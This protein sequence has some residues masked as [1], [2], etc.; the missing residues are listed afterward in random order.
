MDSTRLLIVDADETASDRLVM[1]LTAG[2]LNI[3][4]ERADTP[5]GIEVALRW[6]EPHVVLLTAG[7]PGVDSM[8]VL[9]LVQEVCPHVQLV[10]VMNAP[11]D[12]PPPQVGVRAAGCIL[13]SDP[14]RLHEAVRDAAKESRT[15]RS[16]WRADRALKDSE[17]RFRLFMD[18]RPGAA[19]I[20]DLDRSSSQ[21][22]ACEPSAP[23]RSMGDLCG[24]RTARGD[25]AVQ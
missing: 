19:Y 5:I 8:R 10:F 9:D 13:R 14:R 25:C 12:E 1:T 6:F 4:A 24:C 21:R 20:R 11:Q 17:V 23:D 18:N 7:L 15:R 3:A 16:L 22:S 2:G